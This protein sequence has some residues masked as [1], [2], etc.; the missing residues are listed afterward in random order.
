[1]QEKDMIRY[2]RMEVTHMKDLRS[3]FIHVNRN[4][5]GYS[6]ETLSYGICTPSYLLKIENN[7]VK[8]SDDI[9]SFLF[10]KMELEYTRSKDVQYIYEK[11]DLFFNH[12]FADSIKCK[13]IC[14]ELLK[15][16]HVVEYTQAFIYF[17]IFKLYSK[18]FIAQDNVSEI[19]LQE[20]EEY[21]NDKE[22]LLYDLYRGLYLGEETELTKQDPTDIYI[23]KAKA[24]ILSRKGLYL[25]AYDALQKAYH[26][27]CNEADMIGMGDILLAL[28]HV[29]SYIDIKA[30]EQ[31]YSNTVKGNP[32][33]DAKAFAYFNIGSAFIEKN[34]YNEALSYL[35]EG[36]KA[37]Q[38]E[39]LLIQ[40]YERIFICYC[41][42]GEEADKHRYFDKLSQSRYYPI[43]EIMNANQQYDYDRKYVE[44]VR[45]IRNDNLVFR[46][47]HRI[48]CIRN[49]RYKEYF[50]D[51]Y[52][53]E[54][55]V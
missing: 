30:M 49:R 21:M 20:Y 51:S 34:K 6:V 22:K 46:H 54:K 35:L 16:E 29:S 3:L 2:N 31:V 19:N 43:F 15:E 12:F 39:K 10:R 32:D 8:T 23:L 37:C 48:N 53:A 14:L 36:E 7:E 38:K 41:L 5:L 50:A 1:M 17:Q 4:K 18:D 27:A 55:I 28:D 47:I 40:Y 25:E 9:Y 26:I 44:I 33:N 42:I 52:F 24:N 45:D 13:K 11:I